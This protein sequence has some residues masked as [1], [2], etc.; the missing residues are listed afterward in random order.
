MKMRLFYL[1]IVIACVGSAHAGD[2]PSPSKALD[3]GAADR[4]Y[5]VSVLQ[6]I[7]EPVLAGLAAGKPDLPTHDWERDRSEFAALEAFGRTLSGI[8]PWL[9]LGPDSTDEGKLRARFIELTVKAT[10]NATDPHSLGHLNFCDGG[11]QP[12]VD[13][14]FFAQGLL[15]ARRQVW[16]KLNSSQQSNVV[17][18]L[19]SSRVIHPGENNWVLFSAMV[20]AALW[21]LTGECE[22][23]SIEYAVRRHME[24]YKG[25]GTYGDGPDFHWDYYNSYV[26]QPMLVE[27]LEVCQ[28]KHDSLGKLYPKALERLR[29][30]A[31]IQERLI[32]P[33]GTYPVLGRSSAYRFG[34]FQAL[35]KLA[36]MNELPR[37]LKP[38]A[39]RS[40]L[41]AVIRRSIEASGTFDDKGWLQ[42]G[43]AGHQPSVRE[44]YISTGSLYLCTV[45][46]LD[47]GLPADDLFWT[48]PAS[49]WTQK[50]IWSG[51]DVPAD[52]AYRESVR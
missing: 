40:S 13:T 25:D 32:S 22:R 4:A 7:A 26:I 14:A 27:V 45:G 21:D 10:E 39:V 47:L 38:G 18:A 31:V 36:L 17:V 2:S 35:S 3:T 37:E 33:E 51:E 43:I 8:S 19:K 34:A 24:W 52:H 29:R 5:S 28:R 41:T 9:E 6:R 50:R 49:A 30:Y 16:G 15:R 20:E 42:V 12:L 1:F 11:G 44:S 48:A 46:L 23:K